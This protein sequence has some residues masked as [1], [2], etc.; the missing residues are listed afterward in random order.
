MPSFANVGRGVFVPYAPS[1]VVNSV[2]LLHFDGSNGGTVFTD[3][4]GNTWTAVGAAV[5]D[6]SD[7][8]FGSASLYPGASNGAIT[9]VNAAWNQ[10]SSDFTIEVQLKT[11]V[12]A[13][14]TQYAIHFRDSGTG[15]STIFIYNDPASGNLAWGCQTGPGVTIFNR[16]SGTSVADSA[17]HHVAYVLYGTVFTLYIDGVSADTFTSATRPGTGGDVYVGGLA[18]TG[19]LRWQGHLDEL[20]ISAVA[21]YT[22]NFTPTGPFTY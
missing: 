1:A 18:T 10:L 2:S 9:S 7:F 6:T 8:K 13:G 16:V 22:S 11:A 15:A 12:G 19:T 21:R 20:R 5:T 3:V 17:Y 4:Y 14:T